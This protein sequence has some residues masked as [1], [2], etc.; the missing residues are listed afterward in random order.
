MWLLLVVVVLLLLGRVLSPLPL[1]KSSRR[2]LLGHEGWTRPEL[3]GPRG[4]IGR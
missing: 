3:L 2:S 4:E 1:R